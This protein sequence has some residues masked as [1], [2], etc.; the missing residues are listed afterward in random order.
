MEGQIL[1]PCKACDGLL[2]H[3]IHSPI[4]Q[5]ERIPYVINRKPGD[6]LFPMKAEYR[7]RN[8]GSDRT[9]EWERVNE[10]A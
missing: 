8:C 5:G 1:G 4:P 2:I 7:C 6:R 9:S 10:C 3:V